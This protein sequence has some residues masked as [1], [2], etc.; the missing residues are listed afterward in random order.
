MMTD[1]ELKLRVAAENLLVMCKRAGLSHMSVTVIP[2]GGQR[3]D[4]DWANA[5]A[6]DGD[7]LVAEVRICR[8]PNE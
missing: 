7:E 2:D 8:D 4:F 6:W 1:V 3:G 5:V